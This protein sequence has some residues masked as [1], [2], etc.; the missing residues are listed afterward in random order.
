[1]EPRIHEIPPEKV[2]GI[3]EELERYGMVNIEVEN[4]AS[5]F[6]DMLDS[7]EE[8]L[9]YAREK[10]EEGNVD[11]AVLVVKDGRGIL[12]VKIENVVEIRAELEDYGRL[13]RDW[14]IGER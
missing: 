3:F 10:L 1:M 11:K 13:M 7:T 14:N 12:V 6:D 5:L 4:L 8:R 9:R 2:R